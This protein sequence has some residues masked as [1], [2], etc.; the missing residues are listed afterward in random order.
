VPEPVAEP[1]AV[2]VAV[3][4]VVAVAVALAV[5]VPLPVDDAVAGADEDAVAEEVTVVERVAEPVAV[6]VAVPLADAVV[7][8]V[9]LAEDTGRGSGSTGS[10]LIVKGLLVD[11]VPGSLMEKRVLREASMPVITAPLI[12]HAT[13]A[14][15]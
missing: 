8:A 4:L 10:M 15:S 11:A 6:R 2:R 7:V 12:C 5:A 3:A 1:V 13:A 9:A 14:V